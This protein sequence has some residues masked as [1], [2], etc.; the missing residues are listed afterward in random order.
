M[1]FFYRKNFIKYNLVFTNQSIVQ[2]NTFIQALQTIKSQVQAWQFKYLLKAPVAG[3]VS[4]TG[5]FRENQEIKI[6]QTLFYVQPDSISYFVEM[7][8]SQYNFGKV[9]KGQQVLLKF[10]AYPFEQYGAVVGKID[11]I[12]TTASDSG[13]PDGLITNYKKPLLYRNGLFAQVDIIAENMR[14]LQRFYYNLARQIKR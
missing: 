8:I 5:F 3:T 1:R 2:K 14:L 9:K 12:N 13:L 7:L 11:Y 4:F 6:G 10:Q